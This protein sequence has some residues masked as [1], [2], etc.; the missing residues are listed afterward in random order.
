[1]NLNTLYL[2]FY[3]AMVFIFDKF[4][5]IGSNLPLTK[6]NMI[7]QWLKYGKRISLKDHFDYTTV[8]AG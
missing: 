8:D 1:M 4:R 5:R 7:C 6:K 3:K 2:S